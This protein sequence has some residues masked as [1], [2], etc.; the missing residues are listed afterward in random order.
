LAREAVEAEAYSRRLARA[1]R[2]G[3]AAKIQNYADKAAVSFL[4]ASG[5]LVIG[6]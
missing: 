6:S 1:V 4:S 3:Y 5:A 2:G